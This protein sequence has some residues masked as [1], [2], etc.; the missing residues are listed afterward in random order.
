MWVLLVMVV[1]VSGAGGHGGAACNS[2]GERC[3]GV[4]DGGIEGEGGEWWW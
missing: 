1:A 2:I 4:I 3:V